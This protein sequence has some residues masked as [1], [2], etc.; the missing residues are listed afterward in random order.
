MERINFSSLGAVR[1]AAKGEGAPKPKMSSD[2]G[3]A[4]IAARDARSAEYRAN[5]QARLAEKRNAP[6][7]APAAAPETVRSHAVVVGGKTYEGQTHLDAY[8]QALREHGGVDPGGSRRNLFITTNGRLIGHPEALELSRDAL[9]MAPAGERLNFQSLNAQPKNTVRSAAPPIPTTMP[10]QE[11]AAAMSDTAPRYTPDDPNE[12]AAMR[13]RAAV[14]HHGGPTTGIGGEIPFLIQHYYDR[15]MSGPRAMERVAHGELDPLSREGIGAGM[16]AAWS[17]PMQSP[18]VPRGSV[19][20]GGGKIIQPQG[21]WK[22]Q[23]EPFTPNQYEAAKSTYVPHANENKMAGPPEDPNAALNRARVE[24]EIHR[25]L[26]PPGE[27]PPAV[28][29]FT[30]NQYGTSP[31]TYTPGANSNVPGGGKGAA[32][33]DVD[34]SLRR[35]NDI[36]GRLG[37]DKT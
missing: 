31:H 9:G 30:P 11:P 4:D 34:S 17:L 12:R 32:Q 27:T 8:N 19:G 20:V 21:S 1:G 37:D 18:F 22:P 5:L 6:A 15:A 16:G 29:S 10:A 35:L 25:L 33:W 13:T 3:P 7:Y 2:L 28:P 26:P 23:V 14:Q 36:L 24:D